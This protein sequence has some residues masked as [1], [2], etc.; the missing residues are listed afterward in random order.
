[1]CKA[2]SA[3]ES[4]CLKG[5]ID[6]FHHGDWT[7]FLHSMQESTTGLKLDSSS[8]STQL[9]NDRNM[10]FLNT[11]L[12]PA[13]I[14][15]M[16]NNEIQNEL[17]NATNNTNGSTASFSQSLH[18]MPSSATTAA[19]EHQK[20]PKDGCEWHG[21]R[22]PRQEVDLNSNSKSHI[23]K[24]GKS[25]SDHAQKN[26]N[27][28][29]TGFDVP[30]MRCPLQRTLD[31]ACITKL[32]ANTEGALD[33]IIGSSQSSKSH[34]NKRQLG[35]Q[36]CPTIVQTNCRKKMAIPLNGARN[37]LP[38]IEGVNPYT[39]KLICNYLHRCQIQRCHPSFHTIHNIFINAKLRKKTQLPSQYNES[40]KSDLD[41]ISS[42]S[43]PSQESQEAG[44]SNSHL[45]CKLWISCTMRQ[46][47]ADLVV[48]LWRCSQQTPFMQSTKRPS[49][50]FRPFAAGVLFAMRRGIVICKSLTLIPYSKSIDQTLGI[51]QTIKRGTAA[52]RVHLQ[53]YKGVSTIQRC[54][55]SLLNEKEVAV[56]YE[57]A[58]KIATKLQSLFESSELDQT[59]PVGVLHLKKTNKPAS[60]NV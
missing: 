23:C 25:A 50:I 6:E 44:G 1:M 3:Y 37:N 8:E 36:D 7:N 41:C 59:S 10:E 18:A 17:L 38:T 27:N 53:A 28:E 45:P 24:A 58:I 30:N 40:K 2:T 5:L 11:D 46:L 48:E 12:T 43:M 52:H 60:N 4:D 33:M 55:G 20:Q 21:Q 47:L 32:T 42:M 9:E 29:L 39:A 56:V 13:S 15:M 51:T 26:L 14:M 31:D 49:D 57:S 34:F 19:F 22:Q 35:S 54:I 16:S